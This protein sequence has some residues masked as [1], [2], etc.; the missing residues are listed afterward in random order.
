MTDRITLQAMRFEGHHGVSDEER[1]FP[2]ELEVDLVVDRPGRP[3]ALV[4]VKSTAQVTDQ[5]LRHLQAVLQRGL[6][7]GVEFHE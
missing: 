5:H 4:E 7:G 3:T 6:A 1:L 2:Q